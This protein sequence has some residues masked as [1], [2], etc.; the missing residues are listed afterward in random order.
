MNYFKNQLAK[1][2]KQKV[3][4]FLLI[5]AFSL[6][7][8]FSVYL[9]L[10]EPVNLP[11]T[12]T[13][14]K[15]EAS[16][17][18]DRYQANQSGSPDQQEVYQLLLENNT[19]TSRQLSNLIM[20]E[21]ERF[22]QTSIQIAELKKQIWASE[23][24]DKAFLPPMWTIEQEQTVYQAL[25]EQEKEPVLTAANTQTAVALAIML[26]LNFGFFFWAFLPVTI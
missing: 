23:V 25:A 16:R 4:I 17:L 2:V 24:D 18:V 13:A 20:E 22:N 14:E 19:L 6:G 7:C 9:K 8:S 1:A 5:G 26:L 11:A 10:M 21:Y 12:I 3:F 15:A